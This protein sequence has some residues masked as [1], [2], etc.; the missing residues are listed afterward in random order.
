MK[1][2]L[3]LSIIMPCYNVGGT[4][5]RAIESVLQQCT[6]FK[7]EIIIIDDCSNDN[8]PD[9]FNKYEAMYDFIK[10]IRHE[11]NMGNA[12]SYYDGLSVAQGEYFCVL[13]GDDYYTVRDKLQK[14]VDFLEGDAKQEYA[15]VTHY[16][17]TDLGDGFVNLPDQRDIEEFN[18]VDFMTQ[19]SGYY[20]TTAYMYRNIY[21]GNVPE[22]FKAEEFRGDTVRTAFQLMYTNKKIKV[23][24]FVGS[25]YVFSHNG[26]WSSM[27]EKQQV[28][29]QIQIWSDLR[30]NSRSK[31]EQSLF[32]KLVKINMGKLKVASDHYREYQSI[33]IDTCLDRLKQCAST[34]AFSEQERDFIFNGIFCSEFIDSACATLGYVYRTYHP[35]HVQKEAKKD[36]IAIFIGVLSPQGGGIFKE[37]TEI[38]EF[39]PDKEIYVVATMSGQSDGMAIEIL[40]KYPNVHPYIIQ[41]GSK[42]KMQVLSELYTFILPEKAYYYTSHNETYSQA[43]MQSGPCKNITLFSFDHGFVCGLTNSYIDC[44]IAKRP[45][46]FE[47]LKKR[48]GNKVIYIPTWN[49]LDKCSKGLKYIPFNEHDKLITA[50]SAARFYKVDGVKPYVYLDMILNLL[51]K[52]G[53]RHYHM[54]PIPEDKLDYIKSYIREHSMSEDSFIHIP[55]TE[56]PPITAL[57]NH[58]DIFIEPFPTVSYKLTLGMLSYGIP[59]FI[60]E[61]FLRMSMVDFIYPERLS[62]RTEDEFYNTL[63]SLKAE[64][65]AEH[66]RLSETYFKETHSIQ[67][68]QDAFVEE[69]S[70]PFPKHVYAVDNIVHEIRDYLRVY[71]NNTKERLVKVM[72][73]SAKPV[74]KPQTIASFESDVIS[75]RNLDFKKPYLYR[76]FRGLIRCYQEHGAEYTLWRIKV[77]LIGNERINAG[78]IKPWQRFKDLLKYI[79]PPPLRAFNREVERII[80]ANAEL[81]HE[82]EKLKYQNKWFFE[83][84]TKILG[85]LIESN[86]KSKNKFVDTALEEQ[87]K[88]VTE[89]RISKEQFTNELSAIKNNQRVIKD[90]QSL[91]NRA[92]NETLWANIYNN[93]VSSSKWLV[94]KTVSPGRWAAGYPCLYAIYCILDKMQPKRIL[95]LGYGQSTRLISQYAKANQ[96]VEHFVVEHD[97]NWIEFFSKKQEPFTN[98]RIVELDTE[99]VTYH[100]A[101][102]VLVFSGFEEEFSKLKFDFIIIDAP[103]GA[104]PDYNRKIM[105]R[106]DVLRILPT[107]LERSFVI[108]LDDFERQGERTTAAEID[109]ILKVSGIE[110]KTGTYSGS[111]DTKI[112]CSRDL[113]FLCSL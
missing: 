16:Y 53:G 57:E 108:I 10:V 67:K 13:D 56:S 55:W 88:L 47:M 23:L 109:M 6:N 69:K 65:L 22:L 63:A 3:K 37:I 19:N 27:Q 68:V 71:G 90:N 100:E 49:T 46:D 9:I 81:K 64:D 5:K 106:I 83:D 31:L 11:E 29:K 20:H 8:G 74:T 44:I 96:Q 45:S 54:G 43:L 33:G 110:F 103:F 14:Q 28:Y 105:S 112:W 101:E 35:Q 40:S 75:D 80:T 77:H 111:K 48:F 70:F 91:Q 62:W 73:S 34:Y 25:A 18:Y 17:I 76:K 52:T 12:M 107:C 39:Y 4:F 98:T 102:N 86:N 87:K 21:Q 7:Y 15:G 61:S 72:Y 99:R 1:D 97:S 26:I 104:E 94:D 113:S 82:I 60:Q 58:V 85:E 78:S 42:S 30:D 38:I 84:K 24:N 41:N 79:L 95:E 93:T 59:I 36:N 50:C 2:S 66:S 89:L 51:R 32:D 92:I